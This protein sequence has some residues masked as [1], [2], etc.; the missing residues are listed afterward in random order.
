MILRDV[1]SLYESPEIEE[2][3]LQV[4]TGIASTGTFSIRDMEETN[5]W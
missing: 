4:E 1:K 5:D 2:I 3:Q